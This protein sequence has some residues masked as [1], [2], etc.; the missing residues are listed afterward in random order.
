LVVQ[1]ARV[2][3]EEQEEPAHLQRQEAMVSPD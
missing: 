1:E 3:L 2:V